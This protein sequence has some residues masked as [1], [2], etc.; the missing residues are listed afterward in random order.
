MIYNRKH[1]KQCLLR[2]LACQII[3]SAEIDDPDSLKNISENLADIAYYAGGSSGNANCI[4]GVR[5]S[6][7]K[8]STVDFD[9]TYGWEESLI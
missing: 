4:E 9:G 8:I 5:N 2:I 7:Y 3:A 6:M 1:R